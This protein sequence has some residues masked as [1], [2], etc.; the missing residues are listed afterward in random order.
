METLLG[1]EAA[2]K[3]LTKDTLCPSLTVKERIYGFLACFIVGCLLSLLS[4]GG[5]LGAITNPRRLAILYS[6]GNICSLGSTMFLIG[7]MRQLKRMFKK[8]RFIASL[9]FILSLIGTLVFVFVFYDKKTGW[10]KL[11]LLL[12]VIIQFCA[13]FWYTLSWIPFGRKI[14]SKICCKICCEEEEGGD[15]GGSGGPGE[16]K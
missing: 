4:F 13:L 7:P 8:T 3:V 10:H 9:L 16:S 12:L 15:K 5:I 14:F 1:S 6:L 2:G 11:F